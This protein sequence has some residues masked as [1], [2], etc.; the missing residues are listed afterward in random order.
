MEDEKSGVVCVEGRWTV[1][2]V[3]VEES[4][5]S[6]GGGSSSSSSGRECTCSIEE[7]VIVKEGGHSSLG[8]PHI[9]TNTPT[10][11]CKHTRDGCLLPPYIP[12]SFYPQ[13]DAVT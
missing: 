3:V 6:G 4:S 1:I 11:T 10:N 2:Q 9:L 7:T 5:S 12:S 13:R 8:Q